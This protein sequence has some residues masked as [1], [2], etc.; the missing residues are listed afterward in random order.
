MG[1]PGCLQ[2]KTTGRKSRK[3]DILG[4]ENTAAE[5]IN[6]YP[7]ALPKLFKLTAEFQAII[8]PYVN[9]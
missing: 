4:V 6:E 7:Q 5:L 1:Q 9:D 2:R 8:T 3:R